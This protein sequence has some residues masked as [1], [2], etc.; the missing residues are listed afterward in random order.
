MEQYGNDNF[1]VERVLR[2]N[3]T[4]HEYMRKTA[5]EMSSWDEVVGEI[6]RA[7]SH[8]EPW[9][10]GNVRGPSTAFCLLYRLFEIKLTED[11]IHETI[12]WKDSPYARA[13]RCEVKLQQL[14]HL[15]YLAATRVISRCK[16]P[17][18]I[19]FL[20]LRYV[21]D[22]K[23]LLSWFQPYFDD[24]QVRLQLDSSHAL[25]TC[26]DTYYSELCHI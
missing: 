15:R 14:S 16:S 21:C 17:S 5:R 25:L 7:V 18:Q 12:T 4:A 1:N 3:I 13:V 11:E 9:M 22:P 2:E 23:H 19:G 20:Y 10:S 8:V 24:K 26:L 6:A